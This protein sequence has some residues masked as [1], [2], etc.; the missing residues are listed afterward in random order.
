MT[1]SSLAIMLGTNFLW[2]K[3]EGTLAETAA[4]TSVH[5][6]VVIKPNIH[7]VTWLFS[8]EMEFNVSEAFVPLT[9]PNSS[10]TS[11]TGNNTVDSGTLERKRPASMVVMEGDLVNK[12]SFGVKLMDFQAHWRGGTL[13][14]KH[15]FPSFQLLLWTTDGSTLAPLGPKT[16]PQS[17]RA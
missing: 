5:V 7:C 4:A 10:H 12:E 14:R 9:T 15:S 3:N 13:N 2:A 1:L 8:K 6:V 16:P 11:H 17:S